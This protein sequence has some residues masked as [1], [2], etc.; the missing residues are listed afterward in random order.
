[1]LQAISIV[2]FCQATLVVVKLLNFVDTASLSSRAMSL[3]L[4]YYAEIC[5]NV[6][7][8]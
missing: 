5:N 4:F 2:S 7:Q 8:Q 1:M 3:F 6:D